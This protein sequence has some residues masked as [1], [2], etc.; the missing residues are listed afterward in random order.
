[1]IENITVEQ[2]EALISSV[3]TG[4]CILFIL[5]SAVCYILD[6]RKVRWW[7]SVPIYVMLGI[8]LIGMMN[9]AFDLYA[10]LPQ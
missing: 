8:V 1:M 4:F 5:M 9:T 7:I 6:T 10:W 2:V 3:W